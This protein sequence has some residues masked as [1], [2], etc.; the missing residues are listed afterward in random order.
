MKVLDGWYSFVQAMTRYPLLILSD[1]VTWI[2]IILL[3]RLFLSLGCRV[4]FMVLGFG[5]GLILLGGEMKLG[6]RGM[7]GNCVTLL[8]LRWLAVSNSNQQENTVWLFT[9][10]TQNSKIYQQNHGQEKYPGLVSP[11][12]SRKINSQQPSHQQLS[13]RTV[14]RFRS[15]AE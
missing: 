8:A 4:I 2:Q 5:F 15:S 12:Q 6:I 14:S 13:D 1:C 3:V 9:M 7:N 11:P 10:S